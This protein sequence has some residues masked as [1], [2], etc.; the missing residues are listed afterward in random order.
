MTGQRPPDS[1]E[2]NDLVEQAR[3]VDMLR[4]VE[5]YGVKLSRVGHEYVGPCPVCGT[6]TDRFSIKPNGRLFN[7]RVCA[8]GG[9]GAIDL[10]MFL[11]GVDFATA[12]RELTGTLSGELRVKSP[13]AEARDKQL[14]QER[15]E[16]ESAQHE[17]AKKLWRSRQPIAGSLVETYLHA[18]GY[19]G[20]IPPTLGFLPAS[21]KYPPAMVAA[22]AL[23]RESI[24]DEPIEPGTLAAP[25]SAQVSAVHITALLPNGSDRLRGK[26][27]KKIIGR[28]LN[29]PIVLSA[30]SDG[31]S[32]AITEGIEDALA[33]TAAGYS[34]WAAGS[35]VHLVPLALSIPDYVTMLIIEQHADENGVGERETEKLV[36]ILRERERKR[37]EKMRKQGVRPERAMEIIVRRAT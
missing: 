14:Q 23:P 33:Y 31:L 16:Y 19:H 21:E 26:G 8:R 2:W 24:G 5:R 9:K 3:H 29:R 36:Q 20:P 30:I 32:L 25:R 34:A 13:Q 15:V 7:C 17:K 37:L 6:G 22:F 10:L 4:L 1:R 11:A 35:G 18:R 27:G 28:P 12:V